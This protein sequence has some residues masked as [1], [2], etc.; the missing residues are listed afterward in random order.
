MT[1]YAPAYTNLLMEHF[2][3]RSI[4]PFLEGLSLSYF[5]FI[6]DL[7]FLLTGKK[8]ELIII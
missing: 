4:Y 7:F 5:T 6:D 2:E 8:E 3:R 1:I